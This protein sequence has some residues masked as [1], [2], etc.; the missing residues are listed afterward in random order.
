MGFPFSLAMR[1]KVAMAFSGFPVSTLKRALSGS[2]WVTQKYQ[3]RAESSTSVG[4]VSL[5]TSILTKQKITKIAV[6]MVDKPSSHLQPRCGITKNPR[7]TS[8][9]EPIAQNA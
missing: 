4:F 7:R 6:G 5:I 1:A 3:L 9:K 2:H 8:N